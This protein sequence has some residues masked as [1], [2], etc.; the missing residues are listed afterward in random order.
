MGCG[1]GKCGDWDGVGGL[2]CEKCRYL[3]ATCDFSDKLRRYVE[4]G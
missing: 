3:M 2:E 1:A 4:E